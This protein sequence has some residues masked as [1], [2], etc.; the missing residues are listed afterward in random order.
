MHLEKLGIK[1]VRMAFQI[2][3]INM[4]NSRNTGDTSLPLKTDY[5]VFLY[6]VD[7]V[8]LCRRCQAVSLKCLR[9]RASLSVEIKTFVYLVKYILTRLC[10][11][12]LSVASHFLSSQRRS[13]S[14][15][16]SRGENSVR[17]LGSQTKR[18][19]VNNNLLA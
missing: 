6:S 17:P 15:L 2:N 12:V 19:C 7:A 16:A 3:L 11:S 4:E 10:R 9:S 18:S 5:E 13:D 14:A 8:I 1:M